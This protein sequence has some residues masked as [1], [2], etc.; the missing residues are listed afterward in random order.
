MYDEVAIERQGGLR[1]RWLL[2]L[3]GAL[4]VAVFAQGVYMWQIHGALK[5]A[6][7]SADPNGNNDGWMVIPR[8][9]NPNSQP[10][11]PKTGMPSVTAP[12]TRPFGPMGWDPL[13]EVEHMRQEMNRLFDQTSQQGGTQV[14]N[15]TGTL[16]LSPS[17]DLAEDKDNYIVTADMPGAVQSDINVKVE[18]QT[19]TISGKRDQ[20]V[21]RQE[22]GHVV[23]QEHISGT[24][25]RS[26]LL[27]GPVDQSGLKT[28][29]EKGVLT[30]IL[31]KAN[32]ARHGVIVSEQ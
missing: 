4:V 14:G 28:K 29:F 31:P 2:I 10:P 5:K 25:E 22:D 11:D 1:S 19:L 20:T 26:V 16:T 27:P 18:N 32:A 12:L 9:D 30:I 8:P 23:R 17:F 3:V 15:F 7:A 13:K 24:F 21:E 6:L